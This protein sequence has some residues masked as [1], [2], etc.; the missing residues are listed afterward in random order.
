[1][2]SLEHEETHQALCFL[3]LGEEA[4]F[5]NLSFTLKEDILTGP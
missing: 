4:I 5:N 1:M 2:L 3:I